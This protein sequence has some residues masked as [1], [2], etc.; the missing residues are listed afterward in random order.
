MGFSREDLTDR[1]FG[2]LTVL[3]Y[4]GEKLKGTPL[5]VCQCDC[6]NLAKVKSKRLK[7]NNTRSCGCLRK[8]NIP[9]PRIIHGMV[10]SRTYNS[11]LSM[12]ARCSNPTATA[13]KLYGGRGISVCERW[14]NFENF[15]AD[16]GVR[17][18]STS[19]DRIDTNGNYEPGNCRWATPRQ[20]ANNTSANVF[21]TLN[22]KTLTLSEWSR[23]LGINRETLNYRYRNG[24]ALD[25]TLGSRSKYYNTKRRLAEKANGEATIP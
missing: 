20:Q 18:L 14:R 16:M 17:P 9:K 21:I 24:L 15:F 2:M 5:W 13:Y 6:G 3:R 1:R 7:E 11:Y 19:L 12:L 25:K 22:G 10:G 23:E 8:A 4:S